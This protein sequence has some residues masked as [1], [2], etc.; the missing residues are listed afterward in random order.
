MR[1]RTIVI[2]LLAGMALAYGAVITTPAVKMT[3][4]VQQ[5]P[6]YVEVDRTG[7]APPVITTPSVEMYGRSH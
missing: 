2:T 4:R 7:Y 1:N 6:E 5:Q 3:G